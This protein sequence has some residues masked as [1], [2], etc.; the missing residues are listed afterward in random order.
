MF[1]VSPM[2]FIYVDPTETSLTT[3]STNCCLQ[4]K[5]TQFAKTLLLAV[6][7]PHIG[8]FNLQDGFGGKMYISDVFDDKIAVKGVN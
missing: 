1:W 5:V 3:F 8:Q 7:R 6:S 2:A 4:I